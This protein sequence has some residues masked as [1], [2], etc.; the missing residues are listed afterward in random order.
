MGGAPA[1][2]VFQIMALHSLLQSAATTGNGTAKELKYAR[3]IGVYIVGSA[4]VSA[5]AVQLEESHDPAYVGTWQAI[6]SPV[7]VAADTVK[8]VKT[9]GAFIAVRARISTNI[10]GG[11]VTVHLVAVQDQQA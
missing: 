5:G 6:G 10:V 1:S 4:G 8:S 11:T 2:P 9:T 7:T 3:E